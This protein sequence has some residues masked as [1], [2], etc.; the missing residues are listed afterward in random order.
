VVEEEEPSVH[1]YYLILSLLSS[2]PAD[3]ALAMEELEPPPY[4]PSP[5]QAV[6]PAPWAAP[7]TPTAPSLPLAVPPAPIVDERVP[8]A[9]QRLPPPPKPVTNPWMLSLEGATRSPVDLGLQATVESPFH[10][11]LSAGYGWIPGAYSSLFTK[12]ASSASGNAQVSAILDHGSYQ[13]R[14]FR[15]ALG[16]RPFTR[17]GLH[18]DVGYVRLSMDGTLDLADS[19]VPALAALGGGYRAHT[20][21][22][23]WHVEV[24]SQAEAWGV[25]FGFAF[26]LMRTFAAHT[27]INAVNGA[28]TGN[29]LASAAEQTDTALKTYGY[30]PTLTFRL[31]F[32]LLSVRPR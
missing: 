20:S 15:T 23:A 13:G 7:A 14:T 30:V 3:P 26:G 28:P 19:G 31:G 6:V 29:I 10:V 12:I 16:V 17:S 4:V 9:H 24:G 8:T 5:Q 1:T 25:V 32:D 21:V 27:S 2:F 11:R 22:D 18:L